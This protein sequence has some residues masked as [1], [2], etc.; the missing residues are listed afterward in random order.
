M[1]P[2]LASKLSQLD[3]YL[4]ELQSWLD[5]PAEGELAGGIDRILERMVQIVVECAADSGDLW[6]AEKGESLGESAA[7]VFRR[8]RDLDVL[9]EEAYGRFRTYVSARNRIIH[10]YDQVTPERLRRDAEGLARDGRELLRA[11]LAP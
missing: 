11:L 1:P 3:R 8:L 6:L 7:G 9:D 2:T 5:R 4:E 10:D